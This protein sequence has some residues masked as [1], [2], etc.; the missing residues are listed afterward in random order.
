MSIMD[1][2]QPIQS[3]NLEKTENIECMNMF[4]NVTSG[5]N[6]PIY[7]TL[8]TFN[9]N[10]EH[11]YSGRDFKLGVPSLRFQDRYRTSSLKKI[12]L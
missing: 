12:Y 8:L 10:P 6:N 11:K 3:N 4:N 5:T 1:L 7:Q 9:D 2:I